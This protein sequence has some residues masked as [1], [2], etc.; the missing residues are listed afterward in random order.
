MRT[1]SARDEGNDCGPPLPRLLEDDDRPIPR[2]DVV[3]GF[4]AFLFKELVCG[5]FVAARGSRV[6]VASR[7]IRNHV[8]T[9]TPI[10]SIH[11]T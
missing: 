3:V 1:A 2:H 8:T 7:N 4:A 6:M 9:L 5:M 10:L 11:P